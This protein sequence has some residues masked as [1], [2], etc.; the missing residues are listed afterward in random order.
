MKDKESSAYA[1]TLLCYNLNFDCAHINKPCKKYIKLK[2]ISS[3]DTYKFVFTPTD[4]LNFIPT[5]GHLKPLSSKDII[6]IFY[7][8]E[9][10]I[11]ENVRINYKYL[12]TK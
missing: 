10:I 5:I 7:S 3:E 2:N 4:N 6:V 12:L 9:P 1:P 11:F 8:M